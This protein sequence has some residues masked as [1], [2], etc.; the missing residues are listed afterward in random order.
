MTKEK[1]IEA[2]LALIERSAIALLG[3][4]N[5]DG[6]PLIKAMLKMETTGLNTVWFTTN[7]SSNRT[8]LFAKNP[9]ACVYF[10]DDEKFE[11]LMLVGDIE[12]KDDAASRQ[13]IWR[14]GYEIYY[15]QGVNDPDYATMKFTTKWVNYYRGLQK[16][17]FQI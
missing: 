1:A 13:R 11:G 17:T 9:K 6:Y 5:N 4:V 10:L 8:A 16:V 2:G 3:A 15:P 7:K 14:D 12:I